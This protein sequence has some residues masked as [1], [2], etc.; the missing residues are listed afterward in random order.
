[1]PSCFDF[2][3]EHYVSFA[4]WGG[5]FARADFVVLLGGKVIV[6]EVDEHQHQGYGVSCDVARMANLYEAWALE[7]N[8]LPVRIIRYNPHAFQVDGKAA[9]VKRSVR[10]A[11]LLE[12]VRDASKRPGDGL[13]I[14]YMYFDMDG[15]QP[16]VLQDPAFT[17]ADCCVDA[18]A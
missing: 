5:T 16:V 3:R 13:Q 12:A 6:L 17:L 10:E 9:K 4:C 2:K 1:M 14:Q 15:K 18:I 7:G 8:M 11:R